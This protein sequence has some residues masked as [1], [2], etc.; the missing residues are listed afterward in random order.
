MMRGS[1]LTTIW[2]CALAFVLILHEAPASAQ[3]R[4]APV[5]RKSEAERRAEVND[6]TVGIAGG[7]LEGAPIRFAAEIARVV[8][9]GPRMAVLPIVT[10]GPTE[11][12]M[13]LLY[14]RGVD[15]AIINTDVIETFRA[16][17]AGILRRLTYLISLFPSEVHIFARPEINSLQDLV[18]KRVNFNTPGTAAAY[19]G[20]IIM[21]RLG[22]SV[23]ETFI[24]HQTALEQMRAG[25]MAAVV[26]V[27]S[28]PVDAFLKGKWDAG[29]KFLSVNYD[30]RFKDYYL[31]SALKPED[32]PGLI[33]AGQRINTVAV[34]TIVAAYKWPVD[35]DR[36]RRLARMTDYL[37][38][39]I[40]QLQQPGFHPKWSDVN[41]AADVPGLERFAA[42][43]QWLKRGDPHTAQP[44]ALASAAQPTPSLRRRSDQWR[45]RSI[46]IDEQPV[47]ARSRAGQQ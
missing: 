36:Y 40:A 47:A 17:N 45:N 14:Q 30:D 23:A 21:K 18:G 25:E 4:S 42:A 10:R 6:W 24:N 7:Q 35:S 28:K 37:F 38:S 33:P 16:E 8:D 13:A 31:P 41:L 9:D 5:P 11:N 26:F 43:E 15:L 39:R 2:A 32:Y 3:A 46:T 12:L 44:A 1:I 22:I 29:F 19:T 20:P 27:T 34:P